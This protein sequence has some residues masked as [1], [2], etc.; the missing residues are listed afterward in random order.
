MPFPLSR[1]RFLLG[2]TGAVAAAA[3]GDGFLIEPGSI[4]VTRHDVPTPGLPHQL[5]GF[6]IACVTDVHLHSGG[7]RAARATLTQLARER[8]H[9]GALTG[10]ICNRRIDLAHLLPV[11][12]RPRGALATGSTLHHSP[13]APPLPATTPPT[14]PHI[15]ALLLP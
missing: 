8:P 1:R 4:D 3:L 10:D 6:R 15:P 13:H 14:A 5:D 9:L 12:R 7:H 2:A 11:A